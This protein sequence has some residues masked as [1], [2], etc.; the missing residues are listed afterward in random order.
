[1]LWILAIAVIL[2]LGYRH[3]QNTNA[4]W[5]LMNNIVLAKLTYDLLE[6]DV[7]R[8]VDEAARAR[9]NSRPGPIRDIESMVEADKWRLYSLAMADVG[10]PPMLDFDFAWTPSRNLTWDVERAYKVYRFEERLE[11]GE[12]SESHMNLMRA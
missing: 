2:Y 4:K 12:Y 8:E 7:R 11:T 3:I 1:M 6:P 5:V 10:V 9:L